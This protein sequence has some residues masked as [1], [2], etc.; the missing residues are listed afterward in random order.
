MAAGGG[1]GGEMPVSTEKQ[2]EAETE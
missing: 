1:T 2:D